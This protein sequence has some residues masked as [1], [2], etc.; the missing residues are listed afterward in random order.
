MITAAPA[1]TPSPARLGHVSIIVSDI[2]KSIPWYQTVFGIK[3]VMEVPHEGGVGI[4]L[5]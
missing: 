4:V 5:A 1:S 2:D 3:L